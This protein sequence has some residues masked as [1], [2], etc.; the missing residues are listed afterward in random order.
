MA[1]KIDLAKAYNKLQ[2]NF[3]KSL[4]IEVGIDKKLVDLIMWC[5]TSVQYQVILNG[6]LTEPFTPG[7][8]IRQGDLSPFT[9][10]CYV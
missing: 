8:G 9:S 5:I 3:I 10:L 6:E 7:C 2:W 4:L 1:W